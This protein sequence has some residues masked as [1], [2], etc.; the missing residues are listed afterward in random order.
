M[1]IFSV[2]RILSHDFKR[3]YKSRDIIMAKD[4]QIISL[5]SSPHEEL[6]NNLTLRSFQYKELINQ[7]ID[8]KWIDLKINELLVVKYYFRLNLK[9]CYGSV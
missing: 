2:K 6:S 8:S 5:D 1:P 7:I 4:K 9:V 3:A